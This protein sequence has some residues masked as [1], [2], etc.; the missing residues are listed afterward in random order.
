[1][2]S[3]LSKVRKMID[4]FTELIQHF[5]VDKLTKRV[6]ENISDLVFEMKAD[7]NDIFHHLRAYC[8][9]ANEKD[10]AYIILLLLLV[11]GTLSSWNLPIWP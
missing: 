1:M 11:V 7:G 10:V 6:H 3:T 4:V 8:L 5:F 2:N 9:Q